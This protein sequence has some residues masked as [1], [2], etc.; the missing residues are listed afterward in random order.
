MIFFEE[1]NSKKFIKKNK[2]KSGVLSQP[3]TLAKIKKF[4]MKNT[5]Y[6]S[7]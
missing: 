2:K 3:P 1:I 6:L 5:S 7:K 4:I